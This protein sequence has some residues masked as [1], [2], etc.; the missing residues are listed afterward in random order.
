MQTL[1]LE[2]GITNL[3]VSDVL[4]SWALLKGGRGE[5]G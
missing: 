2:K 1:L 3:L 4:Y 5:E